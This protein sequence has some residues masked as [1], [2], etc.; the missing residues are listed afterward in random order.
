MFNYLE[1]K[2]FVA[3]GKYFAG[4]THFMHF[5]DKDDHDHGNDSMGLS[6]T[7][8]TSFYVQTLSKLITISFHYC[9]TENQSKNCEKEKPGTKP[10]NTINN[11]D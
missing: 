11:N 6:N 10:D 1:T 8:I 5:T 3:N 2:K 9:S 7:L 4:D